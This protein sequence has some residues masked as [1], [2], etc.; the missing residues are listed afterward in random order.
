MKSKGVKKSKRTC[1]ELAEGYVIGVDGGG[2]KTIAALADLEGK[3]LKTGKSG[4]S[5]PRNVGIK[6]ATDNISKAIKKALR[7]RR[8]ADITSTFIGLPAVAEEFKPKKPE[9]RRKL[10]RKIPQISKGKVIIDSDQ[11]VAFRAGTNKKD[12]V[13]IIAGTGCVAHGW[14]GRKQVHS[15][16]W[17][18]LADEGAAFFAGQK[19][20]QAILKD[21]DGRGSK[22]LLTKLAFR[23]FKIKKKEDLASLIYS[24]NPTEIVPRFSI[25]CDTAGRKGDK[26]A[27]NIMIGAAEELVLAIKPV[28]KKL[29]FKNSEFPLVMVGGM[30]KTKILLNKVKREIRKISPKVKFILL[31]KAPIIGAVRLAIEQS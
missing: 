22:T 14:R 2:T 3:I 8:K 6:K 21:L 10:L 25:I 11:K 24:K 28:I 17:G 9:I 30:F 19:T 1:P 31:K 23:E 13:L 29:N 7:G 5:S 12:G 18:W 16:G 27:K 4:S 15:S 26:I 20:F